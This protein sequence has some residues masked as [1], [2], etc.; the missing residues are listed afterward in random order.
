MRWFERL[1]IRRRLTLIIL[2]ICAA[3]LIVACGTLA[4]YERF[5]FRQAL[6]RDSTVMADIIARNSGAALAFDDEKAGREVLAAMQSEPHVVAAAIYDR[7]NRRFAEYTRP[8]S[9]PRF[10]A[11]PD[12][13]GARFESGALVVFRP[14]A[15][16]GKR[17]GTLFLETDLGGINGRMMTF[18]WIAL[19]VLLAS[20][21]LALLLSARLQRPISRPILELAD[22]AKAIAEQ[23]DYSVR[24]KSDGGGEIALLTLAFNQMLAGIE[25]RERALHATN[26]ALRTEVAE[27]R[28]AE[29]ALAVSEKHYRLIFQN[30]PVPMWIYA[31]KT[32]RIL[33]VNRA[34]EAHY[35]YSEEEFLGL[36]IRDIRPTEDIPALH[37]DVARRTRMG[38]WRHRTKDGRIINVIVHAHDMEFGGEECR[39]VVA[40]DITERKQAE[41][42][43]QAQV[44]RLAQLN[45]ITRAVGERQDVESIFQAVVRSL[46]EQMPADF[47]CV[48]LYDGGTETLTVTRV[49]VRSAAL[50]TQLTIPE[51]TQIAIDQNGLSQCVRGRLVYEPDVSQV[52]MPFSQKLAAGGLRSVVLAP[53]LVESKVFGVLIAARSVTDAFTSNDCEFL[54]QL[55]EHVALA[56]NQA[57]LYTA[58]QRAY[59]DLRQT[60]QVVMQQERL[61][62]LGQ[63]ASGIAH[64]INNAISPVSLYIESILEKEK[65]LSRQSRDWLVVVGH[66]IDD[67]SH[68]VARLREFYRQREPQLSLA[69]VSLNRVVEQVAEL[70]RARWADMPQQR[71]IV[72]E[73]RRELEPE[74]PNVMVVES[75]IREALINLVFNAIDAMPDGGT[76]TLRTRLIDRRRREN[77]PSRFLAVE[78]ADTGIGMDEE[79]QRRCLEPFFTTKGERGTGLGLAMVY[80]IVRRHGADL[81]IDSAPGRGTVMRLIFAVAD[82]PKTPTEIASPRGPLPRL[83][84]LIVDDDPM[85]IKSLRETLEGDGHVVV[86]AN[87]GQ[88]GINAFHAAQGENQPFA[89]VITDL[90]M[91]YVDGRKVASAVKGASPS[92]FVI[93]LTGWGQRLVEEGDIPSHVDRVL[94]KPPKLRELR[95]ALALA[96][97]TS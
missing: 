56:A 90:G 68:T 91:P 82:T 33:A 28:R 95:D 55:S 74:A 66:A 29:E 24:A 76:L 13:D 32:L 64:D 78:V 27:R 81:E 14:I 83:R 85:L 21:L 97:Q 26:D 61:R 3:A 96:V 89:A 57:Q 50:A 92:T 22:T 86:T 59:D 67:V 6:A 65:S 72:I 40:Q 49:G 80:G 11:Q 7:D 48:C 69:P 39:M 63:M 79:T 93:M 46:E 18:G 41:L 43:I 53:L 94:G 62:A 25:E 17:I 12:S 5:E 75:E 70:T 4:V 37:A 87:G 34:A 60:Q 51:H 47:T 23:K 77:G 10:T 44:A 36:T 31:I 8:G 58:L 2:M 54:R 45:L 71:G 30:N 88:A 20:C 19:A 15:Q 38:E 35:G 84:L 73:L 52:P 1:P 42:R 9:R 16:N